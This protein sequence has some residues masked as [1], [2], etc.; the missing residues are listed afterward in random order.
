MLNICRFMSKSSEHEK[1]VKGT[2]YVLKSMLRTSTMQ[3][4]TLTAITA[5]VSHK[6][7]GKKF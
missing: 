1:M 2:V 3:D 7:C 5:A 6:G 4:L